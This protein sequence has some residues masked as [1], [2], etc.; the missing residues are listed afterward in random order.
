MR[1]SI[2]GL[3]NPDYIVSSVLALGVVR[4]I[5]KKVF[6]ESDRQK[7]GTS[8]FCPKNAWFFEARKLVTIQAECHLTEVEATRPPS[9]VGTI[10]AISVAKV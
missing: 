5:K 10:S 7:F 9:S 8:F 1:Y 6:F 3:D 4:L 2:T